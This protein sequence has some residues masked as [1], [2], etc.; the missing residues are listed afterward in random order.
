MIM[1]TY[2]ADFR[3]LLKRTIVDVAT[4]EKEQ[5]MKSSVFLPPPEEVLEGSSRARLSTSFSLPAPR[6]PDLKQL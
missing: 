2:K 5:T 1:I 3:K 4:C 6:D